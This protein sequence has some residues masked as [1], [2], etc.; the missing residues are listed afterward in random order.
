[1]TIKIIIADDHDLLRQGV[2]SLF[3]KKPEYEI[4]AEARK[5]SQV[6]PLVDWH[7]PDVVVLDMVMEGLHSLEVLRKIKQRYP[8]TH[9]V[10]L[11]MYEKEAYV[12]EA[13][14][15]GADAYVLKGADSKELIQAIQQA[16]Q[17]GDP[18]LCSQL[19]KQAIQ[20]HVMKKTDELLDPLETLTNRE[21]DVLLLAASGMTNIKIGESLTISTRTVEAHRAKMMAKLGLR[22]RHDLIHFA[23]RRGLDHLEEE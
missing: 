13:I 16:I 12:A 9:V 2:K 14:K 19:S 11:S 3:S 22:N 7:R 6:L 4:V 20:D 10:I 15:N 1:M 18:Y 8:G 21:R 17:G 23:M 5:S